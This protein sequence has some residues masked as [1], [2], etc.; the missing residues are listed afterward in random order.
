MD[1]RVLVLEK[2]YGEV[3][4][5]LDKIL[6]ILL[7]PGDLDSDDELNNDLQVYESDEDNVAPVSNAIAVTFSDSAMGTSA[8]STASGLPNCSLVTACTTAMSSAVVPSTVADMQ[9]LS[10]VQNDPPT[11]AKVSIYS[12]RR[13][14][15]ND[16]EITSPAVDPSLA[17]FVN[18]AVTKPI[19][20]KDLDTLKDRYHRP[21]NVKYLVT[22]TINRSVWDM[23]PR[24]V[25]ALDV[26]FQDA[27]KKIVEGL[28]PL[29]QALELCDKSNVSPEITDC[30]MDAVELL[31][32]SSMEYNMARRDAIRPNIA[33]AGRIANKNTPITTDLFGDDVETD[34]KKIETSR[35]LAEKFRKPQRSANHNVQHRQK[36]SAG[37]SSR[38]KLVAQKIKNRARQAFLG[39][40]AGAGENSYKTHS[41]PARRQQPPTKPWS[42]RQRQRQ[43][44]QN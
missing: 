1:Q 33:S 15:Y 34:L 9:A 12:A 30:L 14:K 39:A 31:G 6:D 13:A 17:E 23:L 2:Q 40:R 29:V 42:Q 38:K 36:D 43:H 19:K 27:Q 44:Q 26:K 41:A 18:D 10:S 11:P 35:N 22:P 16:E 4:S 37:V 24:N 25:R 5:K 32:N 28:C 8:T 20:P 7:D 21:E 3:T